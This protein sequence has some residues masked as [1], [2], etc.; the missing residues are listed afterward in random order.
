MCSESQRRNDKDIRNRRDVLRNGL[1][2]PY[3]KNEIANNN[4]NES[5]EKV[6]YVDSE[7]LDKLREQV[8]EKD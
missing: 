8:K 3:N 2:L 5:E 4:N 6:F 1:R 7:Y